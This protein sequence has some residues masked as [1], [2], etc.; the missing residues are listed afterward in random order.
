[1]ELTCNEGNAIGLRFAPALAVQQSQFNGSVPTGTASSTRLALTLRD[2]IDRGLNLSLLVSGSASK[3]AAQLSYQDAR[4]LVLQ[5][6]A[7]TYLQVTAGA[8]RAEALGGRRLTGQALYDRTVD[9]RKA[10]TS[11]R[12]DVLR[13]RVTLK[14]QPQRLPAQENQLAKDKLSP[15]RAMGLPI[16]SRYSAGGR[17]SGCSEEQFGTGQ[18]NARTRAIQVLRPGDRQHRSGA[19]PAA[20]IGPGRAGIQKFMEV[21]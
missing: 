14:L 7:N 9:R 1:M 6:W 2:A 19:D 8:S 11:P 15:G 21:M 12:I 17:S 3:I 10:G 20:G 18:S 5:A 4:D 16:V 13:S